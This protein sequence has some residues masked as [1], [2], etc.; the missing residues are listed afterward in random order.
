[1]LKL[2]TALVLCAGIALPAAYAR[3][4]N[5]ASKVE[6]A[7]LTQ[8]NSGPAGRVTRSVHC[9][10]GGRHA[11]DCTLTSV[12]STT[13]GAHAVVRDGRVETSWSPLRG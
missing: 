11:Y 10:P 5:G 8:A 13:L 4:G 6:R 2:L 3:G 7:L 9:T 1:M 12:R